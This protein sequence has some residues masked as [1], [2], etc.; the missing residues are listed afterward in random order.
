MMFDVVA[1]GE[2]LI[3]F[4]PTGKGENNNP[5]FEMNPGGAPANCLAALSA[6][7]TRTAFI[8][9]VGNDKFGNFLIDSLREAGIN[10]TGISKTDD[11]PTTMA[12]VHLSEDG[13]RDFTFIRKP[14]ADILLHIEDV[15]LALIDN[16]SIVHF[17]SLSLTDDPCRKTVLHIIEYAREK[18]KLISFDPNYRPLLWKSEREA[19]K[20]MDTGMAMADFVKMSEQE[21]KLLT[22]ANDIAEGAKRLIKRGLKKVFVTS[23][24]MGAFYMDNRESGFVPAYKVKALDTTGCGDAFMGAVL[25]KMMCKDNYNLREMTQFANAVGAICATRKGGIPAMPQMQEVMNMISCPFFCQ[26]LQ[27]GLNFFG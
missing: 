1:I 22:D 12:F 17:G 21:L 19:V 6:L 18:G 13:E 3:D 15:D 24:E 25:F 9:K 26:L 20:W 27:S 16:A 8:G 11:S 23:G 14:G 7:G 4:T 10:T 2:L 5:L